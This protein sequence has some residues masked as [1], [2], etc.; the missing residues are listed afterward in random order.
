MSEEK[1][2]RSS[3][4]SR[5][6]LLASDKTLVIDYKNPQLLRAFLTD[7]GKIVPARISGVT[8]KQQRQITKAVKRARMLALLPYTVA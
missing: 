7:R 8:A 5:A 2:P 1:A 3:K 6:S 4:A